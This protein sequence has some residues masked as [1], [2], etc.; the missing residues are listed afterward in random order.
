MI[1]DTDLSV[2]SPNDQGDE[3][4]QHQVEFERIVRLILVDMVK[5]K[6]GPLTTRANDALHK[7]DHIERLRYAAHKHC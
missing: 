2:G 6:L 3:L 7:L 5:A 4:E 1:G